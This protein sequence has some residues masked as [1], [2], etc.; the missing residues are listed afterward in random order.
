[1]DHKPEHDESFSQILDDAARKISTAPLDDEAVERVRRDAQ[2]I[3]ASTLVMSQSDALA[4]R[5]N[6]RRGWRRISLAI[7]LALLVGFGGWRWLTPSGGESKLYAQIR[8]AARK[9]TSIHVVA[10]A[11][12]PDGTERQG[13]ELWYAR[14]G[15]FALLTDEL[16]RIDDGK[17]LWE[18]NK[19]ATFVSKS[20]SQGTDWMLDQALEIRREMK[21]YGDRFPEG[22]RKI[23]EVACHCYKVKEPSVPIDA[24]LAGRSL[25]RET[26]VYVSP[27]FL[28]RRMEMRERAPGEWRLSQ[29]RTWEY[30]VKVPSE[31]F[32]PNFG[33]N[34]EVVDADEA[35]R[36]FVNL[37]TALHVTE[38]DGLIYAI[39]RADPIFGGAIAITASVRGTEATL[40]KFLPKR[41]MLQPGLYFVEG[42]ATHG[43]QSPQGHG[44]F[45]IELAQ[46]DHNGVN[47]RWW[48][49]SPRGRPANGPE[50]AA[51]KYE[52]DFNVTANEPYATALRN[53]GGQGPNL[54][55]R[56]TIL[57]SGQ[58]PITIRATAERVHRELA[59]LRTCPF[60]HLDM[61]V[62]DV[63]GAPVGKIVPVEQAQPAEFAAAV[64]EHLKYWELYDVNF[65]IKTAE[66]FGFGGPD[67]KG[68]PRKIP[69]AFLSYYSLVGDETLTRFAK[70]RPE[71]QIISLRGTHISNAGLKHLVALTKLEDLD[72]AETAVDDEGLV[73]L[74]DLKS[75]QRLNVSATKATQAGIAQLKSKLPELKVDDGQSK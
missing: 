50:A 31:T 54:N 43:R 73:V 44:W 9:V 30:D 19:G 5:E 57:V 40:K 6:R 71:V 21:E 62:K 52:L 55:W 45:N 72:L 39:H 47:V 33:K 66:A 20:K 27:D 22:D 11:I 3:V 24:D 23:E 17:F 38:R 35:F 64:V 7:G 70:E 13:A 2:Q 53:S 59:M 51:G 65:Q 58:P 75:L 61:G 41:R 4:H 48:I 60:K 34:V 25:E 74:A 29:V 46:A 49:M 68:A 69:G 56:D 28:L 36:R 8:E 37:D 26:F 15:G 67:G 16:T 32:R 10:K 1:M 42:P 12:A 63:N 18:Y 14:G